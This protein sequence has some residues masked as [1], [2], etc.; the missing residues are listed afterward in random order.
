MV[1]YLL[2]ICLKKIDKGLK[3]KT[4]GPTDMVYFTCNDIWIFRLSIKR[5]KIS[6][7]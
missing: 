6:R 2:K 3:P 7:I 5:G 1:D 4:W